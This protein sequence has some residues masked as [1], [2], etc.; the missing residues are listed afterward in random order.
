MRRPHGRKNYSAKEPTMKRTI[1][2]V[3]VIALATLVGACGAPAATPAALP[4][5]PYESRDQSTSGAPAQPP[6]AADS[7]ANGNSSPSNAS[8]SDRLIIKTA[9]LSLTVKDAQAALDAV[10]ST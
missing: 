4:A 10:Q 3:L 2:L 1:A 8:V 9:N 5:S 6:S 7:K